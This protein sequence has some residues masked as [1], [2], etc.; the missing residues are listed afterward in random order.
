M[1]RTRTRVALAVLFSAAIS[2]AQRGAPAPQQL[3]FTPYRA[4][5]IYDI[6]DSVGWTVAPVPAEPTYAYKWTV[7]RNNAVVLKEDKLDLS[8]CSD[9]RYSKR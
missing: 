2:S 7:R 3:L 8:S 1:L 4:T 6:G 9:T 5:G